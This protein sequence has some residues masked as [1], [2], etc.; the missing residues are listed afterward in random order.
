MTITSKAGWAPWALHTNPR[1]SICHEKS[2]L[3]SVP[4]VLHGD[5]VCIAVVVARCAHR[6]SFLVSGHAR[7]SVLVA[8]HD[9]WTRLEVANMLHE[10]GFGV[11]QASNG[12]AALRIAQIAQPQIVLLRH[13][14]PEI[15][16]IEVLATL[17]SDPRMRRCAVVQLQE[18]GDAA[19]GLDVDGCLDLPCESGGLLAAVIDALEAQAATRVSAARHQPEA[20]APIRSVSASAWGPWPLVAKGA[21]R[22]TS[23]MRNAGRSGKCRISS[24][25]ETL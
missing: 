19:G 11:T 6:Y 17:R 22:A 10:A 5:L 12:V 20:G 14:L 23:R 18:R 21:A 24:D 2:C 7:M 13:N 9:Q 8:D 4:N 16:A 15:G 1:C 3:D 25:I